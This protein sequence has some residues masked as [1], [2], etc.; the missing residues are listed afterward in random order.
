MKTRGNPLRKAIV[1]Y[2]DL[3]TGCRTCELACSMLKFASYAPRLSHIQVATESN[4]LRSQPHVCEQCEDP[5]CWR[6]CPID[7]FKRDEKTNAVLI[8]PEKCTGCGNCLTACPVGAIQFDMAANKAVKCD[9]CFG[10]P[11]CVKYCATKALEMK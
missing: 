11:Q 3:C 2:F 10:D 7:A 4:G 6:S 1:P 9:L 5:S 8:I